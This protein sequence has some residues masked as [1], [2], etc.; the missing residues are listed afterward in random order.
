V[1]LEQQGDLPRALVSFRRAVE[2]DDTDSRYWLS[3]GV[4]LL[5]LHHWSEAAKA[6]TRG[7]DLKPHYAEADARLFLAEAFVGGGELNR[8]REQYRIVASMEP[9]YPSYDKPML[10]ATKRLAEMDR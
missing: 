2:L 9:S 7:I 8:A 5:K 6:L 10:E 1:R 4:C 3:V